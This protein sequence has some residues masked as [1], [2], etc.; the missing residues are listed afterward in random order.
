MTLIIF[1]TAFKHKIEVTDV[2]KCPLTVSRMQEAASHSRVHFFLG[3]CV[4]ADTYN[5]F[6]DMK[7]EVLA[8]H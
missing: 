6:H 8:S 2:E 3:A 5:I 4:S 7:Y 1:L